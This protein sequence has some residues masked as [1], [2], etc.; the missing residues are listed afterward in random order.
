MIW[1]DNYGEE[2]EKGRKYDLDRCEKQKMVQIRKKYEEDGSTE[3]K[4]TIKQYNR[5]EW[6][7][8]RKDLS[9]G[10]AEE[11]QVEKRSNIIK[12]LIRI[13]VE[14]YLILLTQWLEHEE[15]ID[16]MKNTLWLEED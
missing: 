13:P 14:G 5:D 15:N 11:N 4:R 10:W 7:I 1:T 3:K 12:R 16:K 2:G 8:Y 6:S 9:H